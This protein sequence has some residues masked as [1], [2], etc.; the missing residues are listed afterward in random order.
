MNCPLK[1]AF[2]KISGFNL[3]EK[4]RKIHMNIIYI[5]RKHIQFLSQI[6]LLNIMCLC[7]NSKLK[8]T[9]SEL[10]HTHGG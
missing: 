8:T 5:S 1:F 6:C 7:S 9:P 3:K 2:A 10:R 4:Q